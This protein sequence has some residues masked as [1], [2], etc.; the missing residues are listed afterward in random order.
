MV[1]IS[2]RNQR[3]LVVAAA[4]ALCVSCGSTTPAP[5]LEGPMVDELASVLALH[6]WPCDQIVAVE[7][8]EDQWAA[9][10]CRD[11]NDYEVL[12][13]EDWDWHTLERQTRLQPMIVIGEQTKRLSA[14]DPAVRRDASAAL[15]NLGGDGEAA[16]PALARA[17]EDDDAS[18]RQAA[19]DA[20][21]RIGPGAAAAVPALTE[22]LADPDAGV[23]A[24]AAE[25]LA[26][27]GEP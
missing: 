2:M 18:V 20:L 3:F 16:L 5:A 6:G 11:G 21:G 15:G 26:A 17:L 4:G 25:A 1:G 13:R 27:I 12:V 8:G 14:P 19:A 24:S 22:A 7:P 23:H 9:V 10:T